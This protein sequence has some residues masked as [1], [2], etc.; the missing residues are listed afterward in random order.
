MKI[1][2]DLR[3]ISDNIHS[4]FVLQLMEKF[5]KQ[6]TDCSFNIYINKENKI[7]IF[8]KLKNL[9]NIN[10]KKVNIKR[11]SIAEQTK[12]LKILKKD[13]NHIMCFFD[14]FKPIFY[15]KDYITFL[16]SL[17]E[18]YYSN[19]NS[20]L[21]KNIFFYLAWKNFNKSK[22]IIVLDSKTK[23]ELVEKFNIKYDKIEMISG[24]FPNKEGF[25]YEDESEKANINL[26]AKY[27][28]KNP[29]F[30]Y[31]GWNSIE[32]NYEKLVSV[33]FKLK[34]K[35]HKIDLVFLGNNIS[36][37]VGLRN[38]IL[39]KNMQESVFFLWSPELKEKKY[40][41][42]E[43]LW[44]IFP[45]F[46]ET[47]PFRLSEPLYFSKQI[48]SSN[49]KKIKGIFWESI[50]YFSPISENSIIECLEKY[51]EDETY[52]KAVDYKDIKEKYTLENTLKEFNEVFK[53]V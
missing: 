16:W 10:I 51:I 40:L 27:S 14:Q 30:L 33:F 18:F 17:K 42:S 21:E 6:K 2:I 53:K 23:D 50:S 29:F 41:Y 31:S 47:F 15:K 44:V 3:F 7:F 13:S 24:F 35:W 48:I 9:K 43:S 1:W 45:S 8:K 34:Q 32:K 46:Y 12:F 20:N 22:K 39:D 49:L 19:F 4:S 36:G 38:I 11:W 37:N 5:I 52:K 28:I 25:N 26:A